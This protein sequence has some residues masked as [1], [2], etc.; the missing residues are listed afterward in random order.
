M[1]SSILIVHEQAAVRD[2]AR[3]CLENSGHRLEEA[4]MLNLADVSRPD[5]LLVAHSALVPLADSLARIKRHDNARGTRLIVMAPR[6]VLGDAFKALELGADDCIGVPIEASELTARVTASLRRPAVTLEP[7]SLTAGPVQLDRATHHVHVHDQA[8]ELAPTEFRLM[9][10]FLEN[11]GRV[12]SRAELLR[13]AWGKDIKAGQRTVDV[14]VRRLRQQLEPFG[15][16]EMIQTVRGF[17]YRFSAEVPDVR[18][19]VDGLGIGERC[20]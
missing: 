8:V 12:F 5:L 14:H 19:R 10:F 4:S 6:K 11:Q 17:G 1:S 9:A 13:R 18:R 16:E 7:D 3:R 2:E 15:C 20:S